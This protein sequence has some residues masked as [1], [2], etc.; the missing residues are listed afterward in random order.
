MKILLV[1]GSY[2]PDI[3]GVAEYTEQLAE[4]LQSAG[5]EV[6]VFSGKKWSL[7]NASVLNREIR[8]IGA[9]VL[10]MQYPATG[11]G[12][13]L[14]PQLLSMLQPYVVTI[15]ECSQTHILRRLSLYPFSLRAPK[16]IFTNEYEQKYSR[17]FAP[18]INDRS[19]VIP[20][21]N[22]IPLGPDSVATLP[23]VVT[24]F[25]L[26]RPKKGLEHVI[27]MARLFGERAN[28][29]SVRIVG[30]VLPG[31]EDYYARLREEASSL[32]LKWALG[33][34]GTS[35]AHAL[36]ETEVAYLPF[37]DGASERRSSLIA[38][39]ANKAAIITTRGPHTPSALEKAVQ[40]AESPA[41]AVG[42]A[43]D[44]FDR[45]QRLEAKRLLAAQYAVKFSWDSIA[46]DHMIIYRRAMA[47]RVHSRT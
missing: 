33:L 12:W 14:G 25:G 30:T 37:P 24:S 6:I 1:T 18:W 23:N 3:C 15:H 34:N 36:A 41:E 39:L 47:D 40:F 11:Y 42:L 32:P 20:I 43:E 16:V 19:T 27:E 5:A 31:Y 26:I 4:A 29:L 2:P 21:G 28:G 44:M 17:R 8:D 7:A 13:H 10:H 35:L 22:G 38:M 45:R 46:A 9:D